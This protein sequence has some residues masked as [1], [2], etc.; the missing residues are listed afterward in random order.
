MKNIMK[1]GI[2]MKTLC[3]GKLILF[4][5]L[6]LS[7]FLTGCN[8]ETEQ[9]NLVRELKEKIEVYQKQSIEKDKQETTEKETEKNP[10]IIEKGILDKLG[11]DFKIDPSRDLS[12]DIRILEY[13]QIAYIL[14]YY[15]F[16][17]IDKF[18]FISTNIE[19][20]KYIND[21]IPA[22][23]HTKDLEDLSYMVELLD[24]S[25]YYKNDEYYNNIKAKYPGYKDYILNIYKEDQISISRLNKAEVVINK[26]SK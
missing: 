23:K 3:S 20:Y 6:L 8:K 11:Y 7:V 25:D 5:L 21:I 17:D 16:K 14:D 12:K 18:L 15:L 10:V 26:Y 19:Q 4:I 1:E 9:E 2:S 13:N 22:S 24:G